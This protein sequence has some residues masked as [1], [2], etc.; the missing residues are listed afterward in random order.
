MYVIWLQQDFTF[1]NYIVYVN[2]FIY[3]ILCNG[4][5]ACSR[6]P[7]TVTI[8]DECP[9]GPCASE[10][11]HFDLSG[12]AM[13]ALARP[14]QGDR[15]RSAGVLRVYYRRY[16]YT[17]I[18]FVLKFFLLVCISRFWVEFFFFDKSKKSMFSFLLL[19]LQK[20]YL[21]KI[22]LF[23]MIYESKYWLLFFDQRG[24]FIS[25]S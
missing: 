15:L 17:Y 7:I 1:I 9:G 12:K 24:M 6:R 2:I 3:Q 22:Q 11:A 25:K 10:P 18:I 8:T 16:L 23:S 21:I 20:Y 19:S 14:G 5:P 13:G 4:H